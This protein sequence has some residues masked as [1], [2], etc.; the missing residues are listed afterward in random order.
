MG[1]VSGVEKKKKRLEKKKR[2]LGWKTGPESLLFDLRLKG[3]ASLA[4]P[5]RRPLCLQS[6]DISSAKPHLLVVSGRRKLPMLSSRHHRSSVPE[7]E[8]CCP[9]HLSKDRASPLTH[10]A[11]SPT[12]G[13][14][15]L[16]YMGENAY[17]MNLGSPAAAMEVMQQYVGH[18][19]REQFA[20]KEAIFLGQRAS[21]MRFAGEYVA[22][23]SEDGRLYIWEK[24]TGRLVKMLRGDEKGNM[25]P[26]HSQ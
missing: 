13:E 17:L 11:F 20:F 15:L 9:T 2:G 10:A 5:P 12:G 25:F 6:C 21:F 8:Y 3:K 18:T 19:N 24:R 22:S 23:G 26:S 7:F 4:D 14:L 16:N 1:K